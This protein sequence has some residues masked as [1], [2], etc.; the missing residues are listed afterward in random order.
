VEK[1]TQT[2]VPTDIPKKN[3]SRR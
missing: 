3:V 2:V 1:I